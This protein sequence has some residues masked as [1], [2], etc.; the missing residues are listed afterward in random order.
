M[1]FVPPVPTSS[2]VDCFPQASLV[3]D[4]AKSTRPDASFEAAILLGRMMY[5]V[6]SWICLSRK[7]LSAATASLYA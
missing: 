5:L 6:T 1:S 4:V 3:V 2:W 7:P